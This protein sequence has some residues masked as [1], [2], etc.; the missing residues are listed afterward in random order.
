MKLVAFLA[1]LAAVGLSSGGAQAQ[2]LYEVEHAR[3]SL[4]R[5]LTDDELAAKFMSLARPRLGEG[6]AR[7][8]HALAVRLP[9]L[10]PG[11]PSALA[12]LTTPERSRT[13]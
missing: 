4:G 3:G 2:T 5:P 1:G 11:W 6:R 9:E 12:R 10:A 7:E 13:P 8:L